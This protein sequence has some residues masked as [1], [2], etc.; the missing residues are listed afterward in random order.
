ML[1]LIA[2][3]IEFYM[4]MDRVNKI[5][6]SYDWKYVEEPDNVM[7]VA[8]ILQDEDY[9]MKNEWSAYNF[10]FLRGPHPIKI[11]FHGDILR[12]ESI[13]NERVIQKLKK[14]ELI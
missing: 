1:L 2:R 12:I 8:D 13:Y 11:F 6:R 4:F 9:F 7:L 5:C 10:L 3:G 14:Y